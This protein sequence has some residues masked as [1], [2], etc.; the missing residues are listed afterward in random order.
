MAFSAGITKIRHAGAGDVRKIAEIEGKC[1]PVE[2]AA[3]LE[4]IEKRVKAFPN[5]FWLLFDCDE[6]GGEREL[7]SFING[8]V[9]NQK[10]LCDEMYDDASIHDE[11]GEWQMIFG[12]DTA[13]E[14]Q[15]KGF[16]SQVMQQVISDS[17]R[18]GR[19]GIVLTC[20][21]KLRTFYEKFGFVSEGVSS[22]THGG[23]VWLQMRLIF[24]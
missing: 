3:S 7:I 16:A 13:P 12:V 20:K 8:L 23:V 15:H 14:F 6:T 24:G 22:S 21:E 2:E 17:K 19:K 1:F 10:D 18:D 5:H 4:S 11:N 9:T